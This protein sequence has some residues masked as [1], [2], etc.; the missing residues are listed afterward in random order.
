MNDNHTGIRCISASSDAS[1]Q[2]NKS[3]SLT[4]KIYTQSTSNWERGLESFTSMD[5]F[6]QDYSKNYFSKIQ[7][8]PRDQNVGWISWVKSKDEEWP[9]R[10][11]MG[12]NRT[13]SGGREEKG[14]TAAYSAWSWIICPRRRRGQI[15][16]TNFKYKE[17]H[18]PQCSLQHFLQ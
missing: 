1:W 3:F 8:N 9:W 10:T 17:I 15:S 2:W 14:L 4:V 12:A 13:E 18:V 16:I 6:K 7:R 11:T 5:T